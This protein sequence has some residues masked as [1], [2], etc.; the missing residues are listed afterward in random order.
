MKIPHVLHN[1][2]TNKIVLNVVC[3]LS[4]L[5]LIGYLAM[6]KMTAILFFIVL[7]ILITQFNKNM[8]IV[9]GVPLILVNLFVAKGYSFVEGMETNTNTTTTTKP[10]SDSTAMTPEKTG[11]PKKV[12][13]KA[14]D[15]KTSGGTVMTPLEPTQDTNKDSF[16]VGRAKR[17]GAGPQIDYAA[18]VEDA[19]DNLN[20]ILGGEG[21]QKLT[22]D[23]QKLMKQQMQLAE[24]MTAM[25]PM[26]ASLGPMM[27]QA[28]GMMNG[29]GDNKGMEDLMAMASKMGIG[30]K[31]E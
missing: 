4:A 25:E 12:A 17:R 23:T 18:T 2:L 24:S 10:S 14:Q 27:K 26:I 11:A 19:Y 20:S 8:I 6:G 16:E 1:L 7:A 29:L 22:G 30:G 5:N 28:Q 31:K 13:Q 3:V 9:L 21:I 15:K